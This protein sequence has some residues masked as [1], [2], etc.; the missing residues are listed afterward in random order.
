MRRLATLLAV[1][2]L[3]MVGAAPAAAAPSAA[4]A[5]AAA[6]QNPVKINW[7]GLYA[8]PDDDTGII[9]PCGVLHE[10]YGITCG[11]LAFTRGEGGGNAVGP[12]VRQDLG[13]RRENE[14]RVAQAWAGSVNVFYLD[15]PD[16]YYNTSAPLTEFFWGH[17]QT[18]GRV[19][20]IIRETQPDIISAHS[21]TGGHGNHQEVGRMA[22]EA[23]AAAADPT[24]FPE[25][26]TGPNAL[27][28]W[29]VKKLS[30]G[31]S[32][33]GS[34]GTNAAPNC[35]TGFV[36]GAT[37]FDNV[38][39]I[40]NGYN[41]PYAWDE[42]NPQGQPAG[43]PKTWAQVAR[44]ATMMYP[45]QGRTMVT[46][47]QD[48]SC[49]RYGINEAFVPFPPNGSPNA[50]L[51]QSILF[52]AVLQEPGGLPLGTFLYLTFDSSYN[53]A[54]QP[55]TV[56][57]HA[58]SPKSAFD[59]ATVGLAVPAGWTVSDGGTG[60]M[61]VNSAREALKSFTVTPNA[62]ARAGTFRISATM[63]IVA[64]S[65][66]S[67]GTGYTD[68][69]VQ[70]IP[71]VEGRAQRYQANLDLDQWIARTRSYRF[72]RSSA[73]TPIGVG[74]TITVPVNV[75][76]WSTSVQSGN[77]TLTLPAGFSADAT[78]KPYSGL[79]AGGD[80]TVTFQVT[81]TDLGLPDSASYGVGIE[82]T[83]GAPAG[84]AGE[85]LAL[86]LV[87][88]TTIPHAASV[89]V[90]DGVEDAAY[91]GSALDLSQRWEGSP[92]SPDGTDCGAGSYARAVWYDDSLYFFI[93]VV[94][95]IQGTP[96]APSDC[97]AHWRTDSVE[98]LLDPLGN[99]SDTSAT[100]KTGI[101]PYTDDPTGAAGNGVNGACWERDA[102]NFQGF[103]AITA[104][105]MEVVS[106]AALN[107]GR[108]YAGGA[109]DLEVKI[110]LE[111]LPAAVG[112]T[113]NPAS[114]VDPIHMGL[115]ITPYDS[116]TQNLIGKTR[117]A[118][119][120]WRGVQGDPYRWGHG[121]LDG[122][123]PPAGRSTEIKTP[124]IDATAALGIDSPQS[125]FDS[126][127]SGV[128]L[129]GYGPVAARNRL[130]ISSGPTLTAS[131]L[132]VGLKVG[133]PGKV[134]MFLWTNTAGGPLLPGTLTI[135]VYNY[136]YFTT[137]YDPNNNI[138]P[139]APDLTG[140]LVYDGGSQA[141]S[142][143][144][145]TVSIPLTAAQDAAISS[146]EAFFLMS[147]ESSAGGV[148]AFSVPLH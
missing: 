42:N 122:Y 51:D 55:F 105:N 135:P 29:Q 98:I 20:R 72:N 8:H 27:K 130:S 3:V 96:V 23:V 120:H 73:V 146:G 88:G 144:S 134:H 37:N 4:A 69:V 114:D 21:P 65:T 39:G 123:T 12:E 54:G 113:G 31:G 64:S 59:P 57:V 90:L 112:P 99:A 70:I 33:S 17:D 43:T 38:M 91:T 7:M 28:T 41:S 50:G 133:A 67:A 137:T 53:V 24:M 92:C 140:R 52:G 5:P 143:G 109:Y 97:V 19:V 78:T 75:H 132:D 128:P 131:S 13:I 85:T 46:S 35:N 66:Y 94:D 10:Q 18:L 14:E 77:V 136:P 49:S 147:F 9:A 104:P 1:A 71:A 56:T 145:Q 119:S 16:F 26:L 62:S 86:D 95:D 84:S 81:N 87:P 102:D 68:N 108:T 100:F 117:L 111:D 115:N 129:A 106:T 138:P 80:G 30:S 11:V 148:Q 82:T 118:W 60:T 121:Y 22:W 48:P 83:Y 125:I 63:S 127:T 142:A 2:A 6:A 89:P 44:E 25:Q 116:D 141:I 58:R 76:N 110:G 126:A 124:I 45:T 101:F 32:S 79:A 15:A 34:G 36:P 74:E 61:T 47:A 107:A 139:W 103:G 40:W 93:H